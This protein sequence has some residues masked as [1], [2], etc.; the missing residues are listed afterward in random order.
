MTNDAITTRTMVCTACRWTG[1]AREC[2]SRVFDDEAAAYEPCC[3][4]C[5]ERC[6]NT[7]NVI[8][9][10]GAFAARTWKPKEPGT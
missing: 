6:V 5:G 1:A 7:D 3:P 4:R 8:D 2:G 10:S 9:A